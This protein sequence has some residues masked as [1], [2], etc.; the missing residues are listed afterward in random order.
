MNRKYITRVAALALAALMLCVSLASC[1][2]NL[3]GVSGNELR[4]YTALK[5]ENYE[6]SGSMYA[7]LFCEIGFAYVSKITQEELDERGF[8]E[9]KTLREQKYDKDR[10]WYEYIN[11]YVRSEVET[12]ILMCEA[13]T[14]DGVSLT[15]EDYAYVNDQLTGMRTRV[16][17]QFSSDFESYLQEQYFGYV[18]EEDVTKVLL[19]ETLAAKYE[20]KLTAQIKERM[21]EERVEAQ[22]A[23]MTGEKDM[24]VTRNLGHVLASY[25]TLDEDQAYEQIKTA[26]TRWEEQGKTMEAFEAVWKEYSEDANMIYENLRPGEMVEEIDKW[27]YA[28][29]R[30]VGDVGILS[31]EEGCHLLYYISEGDLG[32]VADAKKALTEVIADEI[33]AELRASIKLKV[34]KNVMNAIDV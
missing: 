34:K 3:V 6:I 16:V 29:E 19:M 2:P 8:D 27:L 33:L 17:L 24:T 9:N 5:T 25:Y 14:R 22:V 4:K 11:E 15:N 21:T 7:Y 23:T 1:G 26:K 10:T 32:Y 28:P 13:A 18:N 20:A 12:L 30:A 31:S